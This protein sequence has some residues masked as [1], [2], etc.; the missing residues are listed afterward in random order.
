MKK[1]NKSNDVKFTPGLTEEEINSPEFDPEEFAPAPDG[2]QTENTIEGAENRRNAL[3][4]G[5]V[6]A[7]FAL[8]IGLV[9]WTASYAVS[10]YESNVAKNNILLCYENCDKVVAY[11]VN[12]EIYDIY[13]VFFKEKMAGYCVTDTIDGFGGKIKLMVAFN[14]ENKISNVVVLEHNESMGLGSKIAGKSF[15]SQF[16]GLL[17][18]NTNAEYDMIAGATVSSKAVGECIKEILGL[19]LSTDSIAKEL[20]Y[21]TITEEEIEEEIK[22]DEEDKPSSD[23]DDSSVTTDDKNS[24]LGGQQGGQNINQGDG[25]VNIDGTDV[26]TEFDTETTATDETEPEETTAAEETTKK[27]D[28]TSEKPETSETAADT[29]ET[30]STEAA[31]TTGEGSDSTTADTTVDS[32]TAV[33]NSTS[34]TTGVADDDNQVPVD[35]SQ[36]SIEG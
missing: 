20:G 21:E 24:N 27:P 30:E 29:T 11:D 9:G 3:V 28:D 15:L 6:I 23:K 36:A 35:N 25:N 19:G 17:V 12:N 8:V 14:S 10:A 5:F 31:D 22:K 13:A 33:D 16:F 26:T 1:H 4:F 34:D 32:T 18:G 2:V 7:F